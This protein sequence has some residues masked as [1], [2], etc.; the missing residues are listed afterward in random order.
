VPDDFEVKEP[1]FISAGM[2]DSECCVCGNI[3]NDCESHCTSDMPLY[4]T[5]EDGGP[6]FPY[7]CC[8]CP[9]E[10]TL[11][12]SL[13]VSPC[14]L[15]VE[16]P[17]NQGDG[18]D[19]CS[20]ENPGL[21]G[22]TTTCYKDLGPYYLK[23]IREEKFGKY[24]GVL[25]DPDPPC[26]GSKI[27]LSLCCC[28]TPGSMGGVR[29]GSTGECHVCNYQLTMRFIPLSGRDGTSIDD[30]CHCPTGYYDVPQLPSA[31]AGAALDIFNMFS[32]VN[33]TCDPFMLDFEASGTR[34]NCD[35][36]EGGENDQTISIT[37][38]E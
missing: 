33:G 26:S 24:S 20:G 21:A 37:I 23:P 19:I 4:S 18:I 1:K 17:L 13:T 32:L 8:P 15:S 5:H 27:N 9:D 38:T 14:G 30:Y 25:C 10:T 16:I 34:W 12:A 2:P 36:C 3:G 11:T 35:C 29:P 7:T 22:T 6:C 31:H 28:E